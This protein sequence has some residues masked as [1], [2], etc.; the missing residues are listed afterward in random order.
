MS[1]LDS[2]LNAYRPDL[3]DA[4]LN[5]R[6]SADSFVTPTHARIAKRQTIVRAKPDLSLPRETEY[7]LGEP[8][9]VFERAEGWAWTQSEL[10][11]YV[12][13]VPEVVLT[14]SLPAPTHRV[15]ALTA[16]VHPAPA[17]KTLPK[18]SLG[19]GDL[20]QV[21][22]V[23]GK[24]SQVGPGAWCYTTHLTALDTPSAEP[25]DPASTALRFLEVPYLWG[26]RNG[27]GV[28]CSSLIQFALQ[29]YGLTCPR[30]SDQQ[31]RQLGGAL[32]MD[33][34]RD[35]LQRNDIVFWPGHVGIMIDETRIVHA[36]ATD[37][38]VQIWDL[39][40]LETHIQKIE[41]NPVSSIRRLDL[42]R[43]AA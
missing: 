21:I 39:A 17:L 19:F 33:L 22:D 35:A 36:N 43:A 37:M 23:E 40:P 3:A 12:G 31:E 11:G 38:A 10:D 34:P 9:K 14:E 5:G 1:A 28:D 41:G 20:V 2:R 15:T 24:W 13:Y 8:V 16:P 30:D 32:S 25:V 26:G 18:P 7:L 27:Q 42:S 29:D 4:A 6:V